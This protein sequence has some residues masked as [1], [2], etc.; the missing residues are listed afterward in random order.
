MDGRDYNNEKFNRIV[1][2]SDKETIS[3][4]LLDIDTV[5]A[6]YM[7][8]DVVPELEQNGKKLKVPVIYGNSERWKSAQRDGYFKDIDGKIQIPLVMFRRNS[9]AKNDNL[10]FLKEEAVTYPTVKK[11]S[12][13]NAYDRFS[14]LNPGFN[15]RYETFD[16][17]MPEY[18]NLSYEIVVW[19][20]YT[21]HNN[22][23]VEAFQYSADQYWGEKDKFRFRT[24]IDNFQTNQELAENS[25]RIIKTTFTLVVY[26]YILPER[27]GA[28][29]NTLKG[30]T[31]R[32]VVVTNEAVVNAE[33]NTDFSN[34]TGER[35]IGGE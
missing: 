13:K 6:N 4:T 16:V 26:A 2:Q 14:L 35:Y 10:K 34:V 19:T 25:E 18:V 31:I 30:F 28:V 23:I 29:S 33:K 20:T 1:K 32:K 17:R 22:K 9:I 15:K 21:E 8:S 3:I 12:K 24:T 27:S 5:I 7:Q 11:Y